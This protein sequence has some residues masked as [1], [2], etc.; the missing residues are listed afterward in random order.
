MISGSGSLLTTPS[1]HPHSVRSER[2]YAGPAPRTMSASHPG[3]GITLSGGVHH[4]N[5][6]KTLFFEAIDRPSRSSNFFLAPPAIS[7]VFASLRSFENPFESSVRWIS[8]VERSQ[9]LI[10]SPCC[11]PR[12]CH[13]SVNSLRMA[14]PRIR[15]SI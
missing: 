11:A 15:F 12:F 9:D 10:F 14:I 4:F 3:N 8:V 2:V 5:F 13:S 7:P 1:T 6:F